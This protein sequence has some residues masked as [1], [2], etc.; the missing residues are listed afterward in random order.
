MLAEEEKYTSTLFLSFCNGNYDLTLAPGQ[1]G[2][3][4]YIQL[5][6]K[7]QRYSLLDI[8]T[9]ELSFISEENFLEEGEAVNNI[10]IYMPNDLEITVHTC[11]KGCRPYKNGTF[12][13][14]LSLSD[15]QWP[16]Y[17]KLFSYIFE[18]KYPALKPANHFSKGEIY[19]LFERSGYLDLK[20]RQEMD[21][22]FKKM[23][24][25]LD[26]IGEITHII[27][28]LVYYENEKPLT[29][30]S[31]LRI[32]DRTFLGHHL[33]SLPEAKLNLKSKTDVYLGMLDF[34]SNHP[35][36]HYY[37]T[38]FDDHLSWHDKMYKDFYKNINDDNK[39]YYDSMHFFECKIG[40][41][42]GERPEGYKCTA[43][44]RPEE[45]FA[46]CKE[47]LPPI[48]IDCYHYNREHFS[49]LEVKQL[50]EILDLLTARRLWRICS[51]DRV[52]AYAVAE[53]YTDGLNLYNLLD[54][55]RIY[56][57]NENIDLNPVLQAL[58]PDASMFFRNFGKDRF[59]VL[60]RAGAQ[61]VGNIKISGLHYHALAGR[62]I[63]SREAA[64]EYRKLLNQ[65]TIKLSKRKH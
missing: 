36:F 42:G 2:E 51:D 34:M 24:S 4:A 53:T 5:A 10:T 17:H 27:K 20:S 35:Y 47:S 59:N 41:A 56:P 9:R 12:V 3:E 14:N 16:V 31:V 26:K 13:Y 18:K 65:F 40:F 50:Y 43:V 23:L 45:F 21:L 33:A 64:I 62:V 44:E 52:A 38:Y 46:F 39:L 54:M 29:I 63:A 15:L 60:F 8:C 11:V 6:E 7:A 30:G 48:V 28:N 19:N 1:G 25:I 55:C 32:Y 37:L 61:P 22:N 58:L 57:T 49:L